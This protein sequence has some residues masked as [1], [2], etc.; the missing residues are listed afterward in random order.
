MSQ[1]SIALNKT[2]YNTIIID[3]GFVPKIE[4]ITCNLTLSPI[5]NLANIV[6]CFFLICVVQYMCLV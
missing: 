1:D 5:M 6:S 3:R 2:S 4:I